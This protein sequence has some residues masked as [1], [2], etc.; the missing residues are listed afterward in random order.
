MAAAGI[1]RDAIGMGHQQ[2]RHGGIIVP[3]WPAATPAQIDPENAPE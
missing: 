2:G 1:V 3:A